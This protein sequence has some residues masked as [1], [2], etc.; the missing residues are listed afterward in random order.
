MSKQDVGV[1]QM[2]S[3]QIT[4]GSMVSVEKNNN[5]VFLR[6]VGQNTLGL[7]QWVSTSSFFGKKT[8]NKTEAFLQSETLSS[9]E[10]GVPALTWS[11]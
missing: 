4:L 5:P 9:N 10:T 3:S 11:K 8:Q 1:T 7:V 6:N 2:T